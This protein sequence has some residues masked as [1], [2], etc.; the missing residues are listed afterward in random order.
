MSR[1]ALHGGHYGTR[2]DPG[3]MATKNGF[4]QGQQLR[5]AGI[6]QRIIDQTPGGLRLNEPRGLQ[7]GQV[8]R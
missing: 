5:D 8:V 6:R 1:L 2:R 3:P 4:S 7:T